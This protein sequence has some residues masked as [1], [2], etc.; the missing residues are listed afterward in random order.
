M[1]DHPGGRCT[2]AGTDPALSWRVART[3]G[4]VAML[5]VIA[6]ADGPRTALLTGLAAGAVIAARTRFSAYV[7]EVVVVLSALL[8]LAG[9]GVNG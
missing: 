4:A 3:A 5:A 7:A 2:M 6:A 8:V 1:I 9:R